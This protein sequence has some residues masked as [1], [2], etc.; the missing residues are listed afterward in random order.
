MLK[1]LASSHI[2]EM[3]HRKGTFVTVMKQFTAED[4][5]TPRHRIIVRSTSRI[6]ANMLIDR[7]PPRNSSPP[8]PIQLGM[9][10]LKKGKS[11]STATT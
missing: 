7:A 1:P 2:Q 4:S 8:C 9:F 11:S 10:S 3:Q 6:G 5:P